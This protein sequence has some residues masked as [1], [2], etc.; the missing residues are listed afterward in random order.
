MGQSS[1]LTL[2]RKMDISNERCVCSLEV[3]TQWLR[4]QKSFWAWGHTPV[5]LAIE[6]LTG[7]LQAQDQPGLNGEF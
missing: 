6:K 5:T 4:A 3:S 7:E 1:E 2:G